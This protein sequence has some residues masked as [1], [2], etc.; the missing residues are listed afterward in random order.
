M[1]LVS[2]WSIFIL[3]K[4]PQMRKI[5]ELLGKLWGPTNI[6]DSCLNLWSQITLAPSL[7]GLPFFLT[8][9][10]CFLPFHGLPQIINQEF[11]TFLLSV[12]RNIV[13]LSWN[14]LVSFVIK[15][16]KGEN[17]A[18]LSLYLTVQ[19]FRRNL[20]SRALGNVPAFK[21]DAWLSWRQFAY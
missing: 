13:L 2:Y 10:M 5:V 7:S 3:P 19:R 16:G 21:S 17:H 12:P 11:L 4:S 14:K 18:F 20:P 8:W 9:E 1:S 15:P 6:K